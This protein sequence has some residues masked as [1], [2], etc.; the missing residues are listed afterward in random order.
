MQT[1]NTSSSCILIVETKL[2]NIGDILEFRGNCQELMGFDDP[3]DNYNI[4]DF[5]TIEIKKY[6]HREMVTYIKGEERLQNIHPPNFI[7]NNL[8]DKSTSVFI[9][10]SLHFYYRNYEWGLVFIISLIPE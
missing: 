7:L 3:R 5:M 1:Q 4:H 2:E 8:K 6:H 10:M 9:E